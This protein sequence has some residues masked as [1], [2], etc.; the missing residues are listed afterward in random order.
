MRTSSKYFVIAVSVLALSPAFL[1]GQPAWFSAG[2][3]EKFKQEVYVEVSAM[4]LGRLLLGEDIGIFINDENGTVVETRTV[5][6]KEAASQNTY[7]FETTGAQIGG[8]TG[9]SWGRGFVAGRAGVYLGSNVLAFVNPQQQ[10]TSYESPVGLAGFRVGGSGGAR[11]GTDR[12][13]WA[14]AASYDYDRLQDGDVTRTPPQPVTGGQIT[15]EQNELLG[16]INTFSATLGYSRKLSANTR[17]SFFGGPGHV[18]STI[19]LERF[20][21]LAFGQG[22]TTEFTGRNET[23]KRGP[24]GF[25][26]GS[27]R[28]NGTWG[29][30]GDAKFGELTGFS[31]G[32]TVGFGG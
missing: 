13:A 4:N 12:D 15:S 10:E 28:I 21:T 1:Y 25:L 30:Y 8:S 31:A 17:V 18:S 3:D 22:R 2:G 11:F 14:I 20:L 32:A 23:S 7:R 6:N 27:V 29:F 24:F 19:R 26:G 5:D 16:Q 9:A